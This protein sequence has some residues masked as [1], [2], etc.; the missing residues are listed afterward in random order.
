[1]R[2]WGEGR[3]SLGMSR[4]SLSVVV[5]EEEESGR[6]RR[7]SKS[8]SRSRSIS[9]NAYA[10]APSPPPP[11]RLPVAAAVAGPSSEMHW[12]DEDL[13]PLGSGTIEENLFD[14]EEE[15]NYGGGMEHFAEDHDVG[16]FDL[17]AA[18]QPQDSD[19]DDD[20]EQPSLTP[21]Q[22]TPRQTRPIAIGVE[23]EYEVPIQAMSSSPPIASP[24]R[25]PFT[26]PS[27]FLS[28]MDPPSP[29]LT[30][31]ELLSPSTST[32]QAYQPA[33]TAVPSPRFRRSLSPSTMNAA[34]V[35]ADEEVE[36]KQEEEEEA[37]VDEE[38]EEGASLL[39]PTPQP[40][41][42]L[43]WTRGPAFFRSSPS[44]T[45]STVSF[46]ALTA[47]SPDPRPT[48]D[49]HDDD[50]DDEEDEEEDEVVLIGQEERARS[51][52]QSARA[53]SVAQES[54]QNEQY[55]SPP[56]PEVHMSSP[57]KTPTRPSPSADDIH[58]ASP[59]PRRR[60]PTSASSASVS[61]TSIRSAERKLPATPPPE[62]L[63][64][65]E[66]EEHAIDRVEALEAEQQPQEVHD[67]EADAHMASPAPSPAKRPLSSSAPVAF[68]PPP[69][70]TRRNKVPPSVER[71]GASGMVT[72]GRTKLLGLF[73]G[74]TASKPPSFPSTT[75]ATAPAPQSRPSSSTP[76]AST[77]RQPIASTSRQPLQTPS[78]PTP[79]LRV[80]STSSTLSTARRPRPS[81][82][83]L[84]VV[85]ISSTDPVAAARAAAI[86]KVYHDYVEQGLD[87]PGEL[88]RGAGMVEREEEVLRSGMKPKGL[89][90]AL[91][92]SAAAREESREPGTATPSSSRFA[93]PG[94]SSPGFD[95]EED[96]EEE[97]EV[98]EEGCEWT[99]KEWRQL[100]TAL[101]E[102]GREARRAG[103]REAST[104][105]IL[106][107][108]MK[109]QS[110]QGRQL[111]GA[112]SWYV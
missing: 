106:E 15:D 31:Q 79:Q 28:S 51:R 30:N 20:F 111:G 7:K 89:M 86:L 43:V 66:A 75:V 63:A 105:M 16:E 61:T 108:F 9:T 56:A 67:Q 102:A 40:S 87:V 5:S 83:T 14:E 46:P 19:D 48:L 1:M 100:E 22:D 3:P 52:S 78:L 37:E 62:L 45:M 76:L 101:V 97:E 85:E 6:S 74:A 50:D 36:I 4:R 39:L 93:E 55:E 68:M 18:S 65:E 12:N 99:P 90:L 64:Q 47:T 10:A 34:A 104:E 98:S 26:R 24:R 77:S 17:G 8:R 112:W 70:T 21:Q 60:S 2:G 49:G 82:P 94:T 88:L 32:H 96:E 25:S 91:P 53:S 35:I 13:A 71:L 81:H 57:A 42:K 72:S 54:T 59:S 41:Q 107:R 23:Y 27:P 109:E 38:E 29:F 69:S 73:S 44:A 110:I 103:E 11:A 84:P 92:S 95:E 33:L 58:M 80:T